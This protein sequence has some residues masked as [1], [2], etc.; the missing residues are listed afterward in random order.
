MNLFNLDKNTYKIIFYITA[1]I[2]F[3]LAIVNNDHVS[4]NSI[5]ADKIKHISAFFTLSLI[6]NRA[7]STLAHRFRNI[8]ALL[9][10]GFF[11]EV[12]Q[13][14]IPSRD[15]DWMD[16][17][18]DFIGIIVFQVTYSSFKITRELIFKLKNSKSI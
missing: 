8:I 14:F 15:S 3:I 13:Y 9:L 5:Y 10:F 1:S 6:L 12:A 7:S 16:V 11:I 4:I 2:V 18:A 17:L